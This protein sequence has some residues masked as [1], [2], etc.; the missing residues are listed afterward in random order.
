MRRQVRFFRRL[1]SFFSIRLSSK[2]SSFKKP[3]FS[4]EKKSSSFYTPDTVVKRPVKIKLS[5]FF[6]KLKGKVAKLIL[7]FIGILILFFLFLYGLGFLMTRVSLLEFF[8]LFLPQ[9]QLN[10]VNI[11]AFGVDD[12]KGVQRADTIVLFHLDPDR[13]R[14][15]ALSIPRDTRVEVPGHGVTKINH[16]YAYGGVSL[17][18]KSISQFLGVP[19]HYYVR[20]NLEG[21]SKIIDEIGGI[22]MNVEKNMLYRDEAG[23][24]YIDL[25]KGVQDLNGKQ[26]VEYLRFRHDNE[27]DIG[28]IHRQ[29]KFMQA[30]AQKVTQT[31]R[32]L[33]LPGIIR[34]VSG[35]V[36]TDLNTR[37]MVNF[38]V[39]FQDTIVRGSIDKATVPGDVGLI[40]GVSYW[41]ADITRLDKIM[42]N[43]IMGIHQTASVNT[44]VK[45]VDQQAS[46][47]N[48]RQ[49]TLKEATRLDTPVQNIYET[50]HLKMSVEILNGYGA[51]SVAFDAAAYFKSWGAKVNRVHNAGSFSYGET[52]IVDW[53]G[54]VNKTV[55][56]AK[57]LGLDPSRIIVY[58]RPTKALDITIV[59][60]SDWPNIK[61]K[62]KYGKY[63]KK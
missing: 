48:R 7:F 15:G 21:V 63:V 43:V 37:E 61:S 4:F 20:F 17:L 28:R 59:L 51:P 62:L 38:A 16:A 47:E 49:I 18:R 31:G 40:S 35:M 54:D 25:K 26:A 22:N 41:K 5:Y 56:V 58:D 53:K 36:E 27:G 10:G 19:V 45:T 1:I 14:I 52:L 13:H 30:V 55:T 24:L 60:G 57:L 42:E 44:K 3:T 33:E 34:R 6:S 46:L 9:T 2:K 32:L 23:D 29:Q 12:T 8:M 39:Q 50:A 11:L